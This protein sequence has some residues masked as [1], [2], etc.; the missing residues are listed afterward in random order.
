MQPILN[1][2]S[3]SED[4]VLGYDYAVIAKDKSFREHT[5]LCNTHN[6]GVCVTRFHN[7]HV[8]LAGNATYKFRRDV[9]TKPKEFK[10]DL[11]G[12]Y[13]LNNYVFHGVENGPS[14][15]VNLIVLISDPDWLYKEA[16]YK[17][18]NIP[19]GY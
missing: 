18:F 1:K 16:V 12:L 11:G 10:M 17:K 2:T 4:K 9:E 6:N 14:E 3:L 19:K 13:L 7:L 5:D 8:A 15:R